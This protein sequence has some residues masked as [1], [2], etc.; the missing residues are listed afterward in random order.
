MRRDVCFAFL[1]ASLV[2]AETSSAQQGWGNNGSGQLGNVATSG[3]FSVTSPVAIDGMTDIATLAAG[4]S[5]TLALKT[6]GTV[7][8]WGSNTVGA[9]GRPLASGSS[10]PNAAQVP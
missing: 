8:S 9:L 6:D 4:L 5:H 1:L 2:F 3:T 7:W 10:T